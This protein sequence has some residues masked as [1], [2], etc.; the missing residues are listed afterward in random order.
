MFVTATKLYDRLEITGSD[1]LETICQKNHQS[2][3]ESGKLVDNFL[4][5]FTINHFF[6]ETNLIQME[7][8]RDISNIGKNDSECSNDFIHPHQYAK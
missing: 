6:Q 4:F 1:S 7:F 5:N 3:E 2:I 8:K